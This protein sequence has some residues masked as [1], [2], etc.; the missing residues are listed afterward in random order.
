MTLDPAPLAWNFCPIC[1]KA[2]VIADDGQSDRPHC[3]DC[4]RFYY[5]NPV[6]AACCIVRGEGSELLFVQRSVEP[7]KGL[8]TLPGGFVEL[9]ETTSE[10]A[11]RELK[12]ETDLTGSG[13]TL[14]AISTQQSKWSGAVMV[15]AY[16]VHEWS[17]T[18][19]AATDAM[20]FGFF[21]RDARPPLAF[22][23]HRELLAEYDARYGGS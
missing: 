13:T 21:S 19:V 23:A 10:A 6:P 8:W 11:L 7:A 16:L 12:E 1:G 9:G 3:A 20:D 4:R 15:I 18:P 14:V 5:S 22:Q 17:G 2:L